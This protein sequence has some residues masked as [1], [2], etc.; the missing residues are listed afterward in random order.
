MWARDALQEPL[1]SCSGTRKHD[2]HFQKETEQVRGSLN[3]CP[4]SLS[5]GEKQAD[6]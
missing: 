4:G 5:P 3:A 2:C 6:R 1:V